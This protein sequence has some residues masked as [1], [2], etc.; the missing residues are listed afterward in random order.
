MTNRVNGYPFF[1]REDNERSAHP[2]D[3][4]EIR[5]ASWGRKITAFRQLFIGS[6][7]NSLYNSRSS[8]RKTPRAGVV[9]LVDTPDS[10]SGALKSV[11]VQVRPP[12]PILSFYFYA[13]FPVHKFALPLKACRF[14]VLKTAASGTNNFPKKIALSW[15]HIANPGNFPGTIFQNKNDSRV[16]MS[17]GTIS[18]I[19]NI[20]R[21]VC[22]SRIRGKKTD[23]LNCN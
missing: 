2:G 3:Q 13:G 1:W 9:K 15:L 18:S 22:N 17:V 10:K 23:T 12:V 21:P 11:P 14:P 6:K 7:H 20:I 16:V 19:H 4:N 5:C 8:V